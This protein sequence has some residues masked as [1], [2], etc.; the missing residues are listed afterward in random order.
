MAMELTEL[1]C[2][3]EN[4][5]GVL[6]TLFE[7]F[8]KRKDVIEPKILPQV[9][10]CTPKLKSMP[11]NDKRYPEITSTHHNL[12]VQSLNICLTAVQDLYSGR[13]GW[14]SNTINVGLELTK[15]CG[16]PSF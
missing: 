12:V 4:L 9:P 7:V 10:V 1:V 5:G 8:G 2:R 6:Q 16:R 3:L 11:V 14:G 13:I 15:I